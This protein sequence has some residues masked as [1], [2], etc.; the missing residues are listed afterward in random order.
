M[1]GVDGYNRRHF[2]YVSQTGNMAPTSKLTPSPNKRWI[3]QGN[4]IEHQVK[5]GR[6][7]TIFFWLVTLI[8]TSNAILWYMWISSSDENGGMPLLRQHSGSH[9]H[10]QVIPSGSSL[11]NESIEMKTKRARS[12]S[13]PVR[14]IV[15]NDKPVQRLRKKAKR[16]YLNEQ[17][18]PTSQSYAIP[19]VLIFTYFKDLL[20]KDTLLDDDE[21]RVLAANVRHSIGVMNTT[22]N[23]G[24]ASSLSSDLI[25]RFLTDGDCIKSLERVYPPLVP[26]FEQESTG[27]FKADM[28]RGSALYETGGFYLDVDVGIRTNFWAS[29]PPGLLL[30]T[31]EFVTAL[32]HRQSN[33]LNHFFQA[34]IG[35]APQSP[36]LYKYL[37]KF[38]QHYRSREE[39]LRHREDDGNIDGK[40]NKDDSDDHD[41]AIV[42]K[43]PLGV[44]LLRRAFDDVYNSTTH[45]PRTELWQEVLYHPHLFPNLHPAPT[46]G[47]RRACHF[48]VVA[49]VASAEQAEATI[50]SSRSS[51]KHANTTKSN[52]D[53]STSQRVG[54][55]QIPMYS[56]VSGTRMCPV[57]SK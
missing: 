50:L 48:V 57:N 3:L 18:G 17:N 24:K 14:Y 20:S 8:T 5:Q 23:N 25:V 21:E 15:P 51:Y 56:R 37:E 32:V 12:R 29:D 47:T 49:N 38:Y 4:G 55:F 53:S 36:I 10:S 11:P 52:I 6:L 40:S 54:Y 46:W 30:P 1:C 2:A 19:K 41:D 26:Y 22:K 42:H 34:V 31:T 33:Y 27:M 39:S 9:K 28:C 45:S 43:G 16:Q 44:I 13:S 7:A 35:T